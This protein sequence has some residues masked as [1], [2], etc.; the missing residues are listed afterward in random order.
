LIFK[1]NQNYDNPG[2]QGLFN[3]CKLAAGSSIDAADLILTGQSNVVIN[4]AGGFHHG[5]KT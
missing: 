2:F 3:F 4:W 1:I 5:K